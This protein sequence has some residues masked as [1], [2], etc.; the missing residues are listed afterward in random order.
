[1]IYIFSQLLLY[2]YALAGEGKT[3]KPPWG[4]WKCTPIPACGGTSPGGGSS[5]DTMP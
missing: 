1:M 5:S 2:T 4:R 3:C